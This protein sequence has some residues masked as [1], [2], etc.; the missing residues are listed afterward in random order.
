MDS[1]EVDPSKVHF[2][3]GMPVEQNPEGPPAKGS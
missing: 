1:I 2:F 3:A